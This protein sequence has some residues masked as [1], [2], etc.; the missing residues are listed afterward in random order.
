MPDF[1][2]SKFAMLLCLFAGISMVASGC[3]DR[4][5]I[6][7]LGIVIGLGIDKIPGPNSVLLTAQIVNPSSRTK[8]GSAMSGKPFFVATSQGETMYD[9][10]RNFAMDS[11]RRYFFSH[12]NVV[13]I[14]ENM[15]RDGVLQVM[16]F[17]DREA[18]M[19]S[20]ALMFVTPKTAK[21]IMEA[22]LDIEKLSALG[23]ME[24][25]HQI[26]QSSGAEAIQAKDFSSALKSKSRSAS[27]SR[28]DLVDEEGEV[29]R[30]LKS[31]SGAEGD[32]PSKKNLQLRLNGT[33]LFRGDKLAGFMN[34]S[35]S[36]G[37]LWL[38]G[39]VRGGAV[40][41]ACPGSKKE[42][43]VFQIRHSKSTLSPSYDG[44]RLHM[45]ISIEEESDLSENNCRGLAR[46][47]PET[48]KQLELLQQKEI[49]NRIRKT[50]GK[51]QKLKS[52]VLG[53]GDAFRRKDPGQWKKYEADWE[54]YF[55]GVE[56]TLAIHSKIKQIGMNTDAMTLGNE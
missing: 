10:I 8:E 51:A 50:I 21:E 25:T 39:N 45:H 22:R 20:T 12:N 29:R 53:F 5:E 16:E 52:D 14:G 36:R 48:L 44:N 2:T 32:T 55:S 34:V 26:G 13:V 23:I 46:M 49:E 15:A 35:E 3:W 40:V 37:L 19:R 38:L 11:P 4:T 27:A 24:M 33:A 7:K 28:I 41:A 42:H 47:K 43:A 6:D 18:Q 30:K 9:A 31:V 17:L 56:V 54:R 1:R